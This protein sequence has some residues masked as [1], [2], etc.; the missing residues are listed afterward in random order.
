M[1]YFLLIECES[2]ILV[3]LVRCVL[4]NERIRKVFLFFFFSVN[5]IKKRKVN[6]FVNNIV[7][8]LL[9]EYVYENI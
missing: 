4:L 3:N 8:Y 9:D 7:I 2:F 6:R 5:K 1:F